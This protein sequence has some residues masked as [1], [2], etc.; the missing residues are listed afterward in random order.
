MPEVMSTQSLLWQ[1]NVSEATQ[2]VLLWQ[3]DVPEATQAIN[4]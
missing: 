1:N 2:D 3:N 4:F